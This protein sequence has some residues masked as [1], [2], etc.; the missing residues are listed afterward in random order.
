MK[1]ILIKTCTA[2]AVTLLG[3]SARAGMGT[4]NGPFTYQNLQIFLVQGD[5][6]LDHRHYVTLSDALAKGLVVI[7]ETGNVQELTIENL[8]KD[9]TVF[10]NAGDIV[11]G[12]RQDRTVQDD[13][14]LPPRSGA[15]PLA[16]FCVEHGRWTKR[17]EED[18]AAFG[19]NTRVLSSRKE[20]LAARYG[21]NQ[22]DVWSSVA[23]QQLQLNNNVSRMAGRS[24]DTRSAV[25]GSSLQLTLE[26]KDLE[27][28]K[29]Q[30]LEKLSPILAGATNVMGFVYV[31]NGEINSAEVYDNRNLF[32]DLW[33]KLLDSAITEAITECRENR[34]FQPVTTV[35][36]QSFFE[37]AL[38]GSMKERPVWKSTRVRV[39]T[40]PTTVLFETQDLEAGGA[41]IHKSFINQGKQT[42]AVPLDRE[43]LR[44]R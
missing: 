10:L 6:Q 38:S 35:E 3:L 1:R 14:I 17:G 19:S 2:L 15:V 5:S 36:L 41:W 29:K 21:S 12:G 40:T 42:V 23:E 22:S 18:S 8:S 13:L 4:L 34:Q 37:T 16:A 26:N 28:V 25:S 30:Y 27:T 43:S 33:P 11:K 24:V 39:Y 20:K 9:Q 31:I 32:R 44:G 7:K